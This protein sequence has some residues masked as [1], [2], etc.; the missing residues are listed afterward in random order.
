MAGRARLNCASADKGLGTTRILGI[1]SEG[2]RKLRVQL[3]SLGIS[4]LPRIF[5]LSVVESAV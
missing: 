2:L 4:A 3:G 1:L 5:R